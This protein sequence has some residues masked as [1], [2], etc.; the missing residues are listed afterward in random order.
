MEAFIDDFVSRI[1]MAMA[2]DARRWPQYGSS[3]AEGR[4]NTF[5]WYLGNKVNFLRSEWGEGTTD[6]MAVTH[7]QQQ[8]W[9]TLDGRRLNGRP[10]RKGLYL[11]GSRNKYIHHFK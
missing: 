8:V 3:D 9:Y 2:S 6:I 1:A 7:P 10:T 5:K 11:Y 4:K